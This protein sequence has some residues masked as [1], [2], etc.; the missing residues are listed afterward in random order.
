MSRVAASVALAAMEAEI[1]G[2][3]IDAAATVAM[4]DPSSYSVMLK[5]PFT[6]W[7]NRDQAVVEPLNGCTATVICMVR[8]DPPFK[9][10]P[11]ATVLY[12]GGAGLGLPAVSPANNDHDAQMEAQGVNLLTGPQ[13]RPRP[14]SSLC[15][16]RGPTG[17]PDGRL[18][19]GAQHQ[20]IGW[21]RNDGSVETASTPA[22]NNVNLLVETVLLNYLA[23]H[24]EQG[25]FSTR[26]PG[27]GLGSATLQDSLIAFGPIVN[28]T[29]V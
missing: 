19:P 26:F 22:A 3:G 4:S 16:T 29:I 13:S 14:P 15:T 1:A 2:G 23:L 10:A 12:V 20:Q 27:Y 6:P 28:G 8:D 11:S 18:P 17:A 9:Q 24:G 7:T 5:I 25:Q 21:F